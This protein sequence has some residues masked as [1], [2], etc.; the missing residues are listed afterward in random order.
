MAI[1]RQAIV[2]PGSGCQQHAEHKSHE[3]PSTA[4]CRDQDETQDTDEI[5]YSEENGASEESSPATS[6]T[7]NKK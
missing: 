5:S 2:R 6:W 7:S 4:T 1:R 3:Y